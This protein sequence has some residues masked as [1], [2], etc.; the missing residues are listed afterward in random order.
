MKED[1]RG[2]KNNTKK[3]FLLCGVQG[4][5]KSELVKFIRAYY[6]TYYRKRSFLK[7]STDEIR[8]ALLGKRG[9]ISLDNIVYKMRDAAL[10]EA[11]SRNKTN[12]III[13]STN[14]TEEQRSK[15]RFM[16]A[17]HGYQT[18][19]IFFKYDSKTLLLRNVQRPE[20]HRLPAQVI[21]DALKKYKINAT[22]T[23]D[24]VISSLDK[25]EI[26]HQLLAFLDFVND[27]EYIF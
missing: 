5:G 10:S 3:L 21:L 8:I 17:F 14:L 19:C 24:I 18:H 27:P 25:E 2:K 13:D 1:R 16:G 23:M 4:S 26:R 22:D 9:D 12:T 11:L 6:N 7:L 20:E 15:L